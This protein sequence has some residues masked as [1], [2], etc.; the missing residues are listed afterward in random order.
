M[1]HLYTGEGKGK[2]TCAM[3]LALRAAGRGK[4]VVIA[5]FLKGENSGERAALAHLPNVTLIPVP[6]H[7]KFAF[8]MSEQDREQAALEMGEILQKARAAASECGLLILDE[9]C[10][11]VGAGFLP[12]EEVEALLDICADGPEVV[13]TGRGAPAALAARADYITEMKKH[14]HPYDRGAGAREGIEF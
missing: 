11:A 14:R 9:V 2:T 12:L 10:P 3:G 13:M 4:R 5:Q 8:D 1:I 6:R 7:I